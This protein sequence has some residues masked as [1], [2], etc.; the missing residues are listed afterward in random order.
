MV[1]SEGLVTAM[2]NYAMCVASAV[3]QEHQNMA[4]THC[5]QGLK[6]ARL[7]AD[8]SPDA[9]ATVIGVDVRSYYRYEGGKRALS[10]DKACALADTIGCSLDDLRKPDD[11]TV[12]AQA[13]GDWS[14]DRDDARI[15]STHHTLMA[16]VAACGAGACLSRWHNCYKFSV[17]G[18]A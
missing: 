4:S 1:S 17:S 13:L 6:P 9:L 5:L 2:V 3:N 18:S 16:H 8:I 14:T 11:G 10:F 7:K 12:V 15:S